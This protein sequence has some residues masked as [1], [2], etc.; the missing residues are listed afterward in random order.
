MVAPATPRQR[1]RLGATLATPGALDALAEAEQD[2][3]ELLARHAR[4]D[5]GDVDDEDKQANEA[6]LADGAR[7]LSTYTTKAGA[8]LWVITEADRSAT[9]ILLPDEY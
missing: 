3:G 9:T 5:W 1:F 7:L 6:A 2:V 4:G 8:T